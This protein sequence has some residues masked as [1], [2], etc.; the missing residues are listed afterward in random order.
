[1]DC[2]DSVIERSQLI[3]RSHVEFADRSVRSHRDGL[4]QGGILPR[5]MLDAGGWIKCWPVCERDFET[6]SGGG[7]R[8]GQLERAFFDRQLNRA[9]R[10]GAQLQG[11]GG[12]VMGEELNSSVERGRALSFTDD[13]LKR[14]RAILFGFAERAGNPPRERAHWQIRRDA[15]ADQHRILQ[16]TA[17]ALIGF[18]GAVGHHGSQQDVA[19]AGI[20]VDQCFEAGHRQNERRGSVR[21]RDAAEIAR[22]PRRQGHL[23]ALDF[24]GGAGRWAA[25][26]ESW[27]LSAGQTHSPKVSLF[28]R[29]RTLKPSRLLKCISP[30]I[31]RGLKRFAPAAVNT[32]IFG[33]QIIQQQL[34]CPAVG[35]GMMRDHKQMAVPASR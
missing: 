13:L 21:P 4:E 11:A 25:E 6:R 15:V 18:G 22:Q 26:W 34:E 29:R 35:D 19:L 12:A 17:N 2:R 5:E 9:K 14:Q 23:A 24:P 28:A 27:F 8:D 31:S 30:V 33:A 32:I 20:A 16:R 10:R 1:M 3:G 7:H